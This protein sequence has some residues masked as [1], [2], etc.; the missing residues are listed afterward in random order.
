M[1]LVLSPEALI[2]CDGAD[3]GCGGGNPQTA[4]LWMSQYGVVSDSCVPYAGEVRAVFVIVEYS[5]VFSS[6]AQ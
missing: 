2:S 3:H 5:L 6:S 4:W 1:Q